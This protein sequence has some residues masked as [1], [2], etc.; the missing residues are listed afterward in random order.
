MLNVTKRSMQQKAQ[1]KNAQISKNAK[2]SK[3]SK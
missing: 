3:I 2:K 1:N